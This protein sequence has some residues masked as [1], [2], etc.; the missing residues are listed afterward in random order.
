MKDDDK[1]LLDLAVED[2]ELVDWGIARTPLKNLK[3]LDIS[4]VLIQ[5]IGREFLIPL[6]L[7]RMRQDPSWVYEDEDMRSTFTHLLKVS[8]R[9]WALHPKMKEEIEQYY[10]QFVLAYAKDEKDSSLRKYIKRDLA[11]AY[12]IFKVIA[13]I[14]GRLSKMPLIQQTEV[15]EDPLRVLA[16]I[17]NNGPIAQD[18]LIAS[19]T[20]LVSYPERI[21]HSLEEKNFIQIQYEGPPPS[22]LIVR[23][24]KDLKKQIGLSK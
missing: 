16:I 24:K 10:H 17:V 9:Y 23:L 3:A 19:L 20:F 12:Y 1:S 2:A 14:E 4:L 13:P 6:T 15:F 8:G 18:D 7:E 11:S 22:P 21:L 5:R